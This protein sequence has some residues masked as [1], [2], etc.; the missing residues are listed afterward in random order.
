[1]W[2]DLKGT[3]L[4]GK[5]QSQKVTCSIP[6]IKHSQNDEIIEMENRFVV[7]R[8]RGQWGEDVAGD[9]KATAQGD[10]CSDDQFYMVVL[11]ADY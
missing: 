4:T 7:S 10:L 1:M 3:M 6:L 9:Y 8:G 5:S 2:V 11:V